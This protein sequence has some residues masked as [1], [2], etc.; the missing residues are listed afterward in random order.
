ML[1]NA[2]Q[3][4]REN[5]GSHIILLAMEDITERKQAEKEKAKLEALNR[6][7]QKSKSLGVMA[8]A[9]AH[10][11]NNQLGVVMGNLEMA[12]E[13]C[14]QD[15]ATVKNL[16]AA[17]QGARK[18]A[19]VSGQML[20]Y[21][22][23]TT[24]IHTPLDLTEY[25]RQSLPLIKAT[26]PKS[27]TLQADLPS[28]GP[29]ISANANQILQ[30]LTNLVTN[31]WEAIDKNLGTIGLTVKLVSPVDISAAHCFPSDW[32]P[33]DVTYACLE[34]TDTGCG[35]AD[36]DIGKVFD[37]FFST[38][39]IGRGL[40]LP[41]VMGIVKAHNGAVTLES[42]MGRG[43]SFR[44]FFPVSKEEIAQLP[45]Q[46]AQ[47]LAR[48]GGGTVLLVDDLEIL[49]DVTTT[50]L[51]R[52]GYTVLAA[53]DGVEAVEIFTQ[54][55]DEIRCVLS[56]LTMPR[57]DGWQTLTALRR[58]SP[59]IPVILSSG[60]DEAQVTTGDHPER[61]QAFLHKPYQMVALQAALAKAMERE[62]GKI[63]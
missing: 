8:G 16:T 12:L 32:Q 38:K 21:L 62:R 31:A 17:M 1:L 3:I 2:R 49:R 53:K 22:G 23:Q 18:A 36:E 52:L 27:I 11:F 44:V 19:E 42:E 4:F 63:S 10:I 54:H 37:P 24:G 14:P 58:L 55:Q 29:N 41:M 61:P 40:G 20:T 26:I 30:V 59:G 7:F 43:S 39:F 56:D 15:A 9:I 51:T 35:I 60:Y 25:C 48:E 33:K 57:M 34:V 13:D 47:A 5:I 46:T 45:V 50:M 6:Q 28:P